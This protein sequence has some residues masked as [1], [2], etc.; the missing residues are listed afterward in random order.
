MR[1]LKAGGEV[2]TFDQLALR[3]PKGA[4]TILLQGTKAFLYNAL[5]LL[6]LLLH[7]YIYI[8]IF[9]YIYIVYTPVYTP[10]H[11]SF[12][13]ESKVPARPA[14]PRSI[15][16]PPPV[17]RDPKLAPTSAPRAANSKRH[18]VVVP[19]AVTKTK[20]SCFVCLFGYWLLF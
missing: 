9:I 8:Y 19:A 6:L 11:V 20:L 10:N 5:Y 3:S 17:P 12:Y 1:I 14:K 4:N 15:L 18:V 16:A 2:L 7:T 13:I